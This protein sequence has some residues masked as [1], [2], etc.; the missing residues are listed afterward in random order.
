MSHQN[1]DIVR[2]T[3]VRLRRRESV[4]DVLSPEVVWDVRSGPEQ[5]EYQGIEAVAEYYRR[6]VGTWENFRVEIEEVRELPHDKVFVV[7]RDTGRGKGSGVEVEMQVFQ[8]WTLSEG[9]VVRL[10]S[11]PS[12]EE[13]LEA[14]ESGQPT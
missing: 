6:Y 2:K 7:T 13:A 10:Q 1:E 3:L 8:I 11:F 12:R 5:G 9:K 4:Q 14:V